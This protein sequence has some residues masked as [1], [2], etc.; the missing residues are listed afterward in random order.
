MPQ[1]G[2]CKLEE[3]EN[4][5]I[6]KIKRPLKLIKEDRPEK[7]WL[8]FSYGNQI[9]FIYGYSPTEIRTPSEKFEDLGNTSDHLENAAIVS[10]KTT[11]NFERFRGSAGPLQFKIDESETGWLIV[12]HEVSWNDDTSRVYTH[13]FVYLNN[14]FEI[15]KLSEP[16]Y[17]E[18]HG[19]EFCRSMCDSHTS[20]EIILTCGLKD[21]EA[22]CYNVSINRIKEMLKDVDY[23]KLK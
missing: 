3:Q 11:L 4:N 8:P 6:I 14:K 5:Y 2:L 15:I 19:I 23:F 12:V 10:H 1:I 21:E 22:W 9:Q 18:S 16:W 17:F 13:R 20:N 7:N